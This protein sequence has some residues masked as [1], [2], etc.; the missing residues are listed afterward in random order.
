VAGA[1]ASRSLFVFPPRGPTS[2]RQQQQLDYRAI[3]QLIQSGDHVVTYANVVA[4]Q[5]DRDMDQRVQKSVS[6]IISLSAESWKSKTNSRSCANTAESAIT[7]MTTEL[8][9][10]QNNS[11]CDCGFSSM[12]PS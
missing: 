8:K 9:R 4:E 2:R 1:F 12:W 5:D 10:E 7:G 6:S 11:V 3:S